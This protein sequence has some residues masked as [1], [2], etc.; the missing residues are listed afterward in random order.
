MR[1]PLR[2]LDLFS[3]IGGFS[4]GLER[5]GGF[6]TV[7]FCEIDPFCRRVLTKHW[8]EVPIYEDVRAVDFERGS[9]DIVVGG[10]P[11]QDVSRA[12]KRAGLAGERSGLYRELVRALR[13]VRPQHAIVE[14]VAALLGDGLD[15]VLGDLAESG[16]DAEWDCLP[17]EAIGA[18]HERDRVYIVAHAADANSERR[19]E[20]GE[21]RHRPEQMS[22]RR[23]SASVVAYPEGVGCGSGRQRRPPDSFARV[24][25]EACRNAADPYGA[26]LAFRESL[27]R[28]AWEKQQTTERDP[29]KDG[30]QPLWPDEPA[31]L[32]VDDDV[33]HRVDRT[34]SLGNSILPIFP[35]LIGRAILAAHAQEAAE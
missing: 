4:L 31:L 28:D 9:A 13:V 6:K 22:S 14:N 26:R 17:A 29:V 11:C 20:K 2:V 34:R 3:G 21:L 33:P 15:A 1:E 24:R 12:G 23:A 5:T 35:E 18:P 30:R 10:F 19:G 32:G 8:P 25:D 27:G 16:F 7:A